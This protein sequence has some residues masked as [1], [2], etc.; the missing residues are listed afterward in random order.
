[1]GLGWRLGLA[2]GGG[3]TSSSIEF[4]QVGSFVGR[5]KKQFVIIIAN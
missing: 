2:G 1:M 4:A 5:P 3:L